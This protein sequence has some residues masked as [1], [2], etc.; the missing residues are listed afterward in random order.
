MNR[1]NVIQI[2]QSALLPDGEKR[3]AA[4]KSISSFVKNDYSLFLSLMAQIMLDASVQFQC[5]QMA[6]LVLKKYFYSKSSRIQKSY[7][8][9][10][11]SLPQS[12]RTEFIVLLH[13]NLNVKENSILLNISKIYG[14]IIRMELS[15]GSQ[16]D[17]ISN[18]ENDISRTD[19]AVGILEALSYACDQLY[20][21]TMFQFTKEK[22]PIF[23][24]ATF[25]LNSNSSS[26]DIIFSSLKCILS[27]M[28]I[29]EDILN[30]EECKKIFIFKIHS[31]P[32]NDIE[33]LELSLDVLNRFVDVYSSLTDSEI[34]YICQIVLSYFESSR[35]NLPIQIFDFWKIL[36]EIEKIT[37]INH[38]L[39]SLVQ[40]LL[41]CLSNEEFDINIVTPNKAA[42]SLLLEL[43]NK[44]KIQLI[45]N[46]LYQNFRF[47]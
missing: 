15:N 39:P 2:L 42:I 13:T 33:V 30:D 37:V 9:M 1:E 44:A 6:S 5:R 41:L 3:S 21:E 45:N 26:R 20:E 40:N 36:I 38:F 27:S 17:I 4:E 46:K 23:K 29:F 35:D 24:I 22:Y 25:Y 7:E 18:L 12:F 10:W 11:F 28:E 14:S 19:L 8:T 31:C 34:S 32:K 47:A 16:I 43:V